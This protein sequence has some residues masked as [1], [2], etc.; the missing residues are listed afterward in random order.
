MRGIKARIAQKTATPD[1]K[2]ENS[3]RGDFES[4]LR[5]LP[6]KEEEDESTE[7]IL[8]SYVHQPLRSCLKS[9]ASN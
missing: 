7:V 9:K 5:V 2:L 3:V 4:F 8:V 1:M 6:L